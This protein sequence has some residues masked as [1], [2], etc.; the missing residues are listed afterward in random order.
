MCSADFKTCL[1]M[2]FLLSFHPPTIYVWLETFTRRRRCFIMLIYNRLDVDCHF[3]KFQY[4][5]EG[6]TSNDRFNALKSQRLPKV[7]KWN[8]PL[9]E[10]FQFRS[11]SRLSRRI[12]C[13]QVQIKYLIKK[14]KLQWKNELSDDENSRILNGF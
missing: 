5:N 6:G 4:R 7:W 3:N 12:L 8:S 13:N 11:K 9:F 14:L 10:G 2:P 1:A